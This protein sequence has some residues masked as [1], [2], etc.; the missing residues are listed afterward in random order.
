MR[1]TQEAQLVTVRGISVE[2]IDDYAI[3]IVNVAT[4]QSICIT[5]DQI[6]SL[7]ERLNRFLKVWR[8]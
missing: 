3:E 4:R 5:N 1:K 7:V 8:R 2:P 6:G